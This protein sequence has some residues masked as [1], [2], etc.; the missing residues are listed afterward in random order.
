M[1]NCPRCIQ[2]TLGVQY[3]SLMYWERS[4]EWWA[5][6]ASY[7]LFQAVGAAVACHTWKGPRRW[8]PTEKM[9]VGAAGGGE[10]TAEHHRKGALAGHASGVALHVM[11]LLPGPHLGTRGA[12][13]ALISVLLRVGC[14]KPCRKVMRLAL[15]EPRSACLPHKEIFCFLFVFFFFPSISCT[16]PGRLSS[17]C[18]V[19]LRSHQTL[20]TR[21]REQQWQTPRCRQARSQI[22]CSYEKAWQSDLTGF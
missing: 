18:S 21:I 19:T 11:H 4:T 15:A 13:G 12:C 14:H 5:S 17:S 10:P 2:S 7:P 8:S 16:Q 1:K 20:E 6:S 22:Y 3:G 9:P